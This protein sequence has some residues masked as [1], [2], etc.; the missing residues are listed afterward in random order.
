MTADKLGVGNSDQIGTGWGGRRRRGICS[1]FPSSREN[2]TKADIHF[3]E[4]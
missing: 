3:Q 1:H 2:L 4:K